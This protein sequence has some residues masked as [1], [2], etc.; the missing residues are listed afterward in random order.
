[1]SFQSVKTIRHLQALHPIHETACYD[2]S[3]FAQADRPQ[4]IQSMAHGLCTLRENPQNSAISRAEL[5]RDQH[6]L[7]D[8]E[9]EAQAG[10][11]SSHQETHQTTQ[12][13]AP[14]LAS[15]QSTSLEAHRHRNSVRRPC[16]TLRQLCPPATEYATETS[17]KL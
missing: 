6:P 14:L 10:S 3:P 5:S 12:T 1:M 9:I 8:P 7:V 15:D 11:A 13:A 4:T 17:A 2:D 16:T